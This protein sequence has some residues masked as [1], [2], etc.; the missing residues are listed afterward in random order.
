MDCTVNSVPLSKCNSFVYWLECLNAISQDIVRMHDFSNDCTL[1]GILGDNCKTSRVCPTSISMVAQ[2]SGKRVKPT[3]SWDRESH[4]LERLIT[5]SDQDFV[6]AMG[7]RHAHT[8][9]G[10]IW[11]PGLIL[12]PEDVPFFI[13]DPRIHFREVEGPAFYIS[14][15]A[16][17]VDRK[18]ASMQAHCASWGALNAFYYVVFPMV[19]SQESH[20]RTRHGSPKDL[21]E[22]PTR[23]WSE[24]HLMS[25]Y[26]Q[27]STLQVCV[28]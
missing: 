14:I 10:F 11:K 7:Q 25:S 19:I 18:F 8:D 21:G 4:L 28:K 17:S 15:A 1:R 16:Q 26:I 12:N 20:E 27:K 23:L 5:L 24:Q 6:K 2:F 13:V 3:I 22:A 9:C